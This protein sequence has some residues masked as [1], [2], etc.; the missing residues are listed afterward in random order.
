[1]GHDHLP[2]AAEWPVRLQAAGLRL[3]EAVDREGLFLVRSEKP[4]AAR[5]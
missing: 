5:P 4:V 2:P 3:V 1:V